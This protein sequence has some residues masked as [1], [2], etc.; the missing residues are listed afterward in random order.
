[1]AA[2]QQPETPK[3][4]SQFLSTI[5]DDPFSVIEQ[6]MQKAV[7][8]QIVLTRPQATP[9]AIPA[10]DAPPQAAGPTMPSP[11]AVGAQPVPAAAIPIVPPITVVEDPTLGI[12]DNFAPNEKATATEPT[13]EEIL[14]ETTKKPTPQESLSSLRKKSNELERQL[15]AKD[16]ELQERQARLEKIDKGEEL[17]EFFIQRESEYKA[18]IEK[19]Q[20]FEQLHNLKF[21]DEYQEKYI[22]PLTELGVKAQKLAEDYQVDPEIFNEA[23]SFTNKR[24]RNEFLKEHFDD[25]GALEVKTLLDQAEVLNSQREAAENRP[26]ESLEALRDE[27]RAQSTKRE[28]ERLNKISQSAKT[29]LERALEKVKSNEY[30]EFTFTGDAK[31]DEYAR[32]IIGAGT[33]NYSNAVKILAMNGVKELPPEV[34]SVLA[35]AFLYGQ[36]GAVAMASRNAHYQRAEEIKAAS[37]RDAGQWRPQVGGSSPFNGGGGGPRPAAPSSPGAAA[38]DLL[39]S[40]GIKG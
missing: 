25:V 27:H 21:S 18:Q 29:G 33:A 26:S 23:R 3:S 8:D 2:N 28:Q 1:M 30:P 32:S 6:G 16:Q 11:S 24:E 17:P 9:T 7:Q 35:E 22:A 4:Q 14:G 5:G 40:I 13:I 34:A 12:F 36:A 39:A 37:E 10:Y 31:Q 20:P 15:Q 38:D 19:L